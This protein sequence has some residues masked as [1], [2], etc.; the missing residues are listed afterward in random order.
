MILSKNSSSSRMKRFLKLDIS[1]KSNYHQNYNGEKAI[2]LGLL[3]SKNFYS[4]MNY[5]NL[6]KRF[7]E[8]KYQFQYFS[9]QS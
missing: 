2:F 3:I 7:K 1:N 9:G 4:K 5:S 8:L 6:H